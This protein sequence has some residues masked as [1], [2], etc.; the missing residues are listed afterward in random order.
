MK[1]KSYLTRAV[2]AMVASGML[3]ANVGFSA[4]ET[5]SASDITSEYTLN[6]GETLT[7]TGGVLAHN[8]VA[9]AQGKGDIILT[10]PL[11]VNT[12]VSVTAD[13]YG[14]K[15]SG[16][17]AITGKNVNIIVEGQGVY[18][19]EAHII[20]GGY[21]DGVGAV[22]GN[23]VLLD[24]VESIENGFLRISAHR[25][26][27]G[28]NENETAT[29]GVGE[30]TGN[31]VE[32]NVGGTY[33]VHNIHGG[34]SKGYADVNNNEVNL[35][36]GGYYAGY[37]ESKGIHILGAES[38]YGS[39]SGNV[40]NI[41][42]KD[43]NDEG[44]S[45][46]FFGCIDVTGGAADQSG[47]AINNKVVMTAPTGSYNEFN[48]TT[49][50]GYTGENNSVGICGG[51][52]NGFGVAKNNVVDISNTKI[53][54]AT[55]TN[56]D[57]ETSKNFVVGGGS[58]MGTVDSNGVTISGSILNMKD[59][60]FVAGGWI[61]K[62]FDAT[63][64]SPVALGSANN[65][66][67]TMTDVTVNSDGQET[68][69][70]ADVYGGFIGL[71]EYTESDM[72]HRTVLAQYY[73]TGGASN[74]TVEIVTTKSAIFD[75]VAGGVTFQGNANDNKVTL[76]GS[77]IVVEND[78]DGGDRLEDDVDILVN[79]NNNI[80][81]LTNITAND[82]VHGGHGNGTGG[83]ASNNEVHISGGKYTNT[84]GEHT[85]KMKYDAGI[86][87]GEAW[88]EAN[89]NIVEIKDATVAVS[90]VVG[91]CISTLTGTVKDNKVIL[92][93]VIFNFDKDN[94]KGSTGTI[95]A[96]G[97]VDNTDGTFTG[98][99]SGN[100]LE[101]GSKGFTVNTGKA[102][103]IQNFDSMT[104]ADGATVTNN[105]TLT[106]TNNGV[107]DSDVEI[108][109]S[110]KIAGTGKLV[111]N[112]GDFT[113]D[114]VVSNAG[115][116][117]INEGGKFRVKN[118]GDIQTSVV[119]NN[120]MNLYSGTLTQTVDNT[121]GTI[122]IHGVVGITEKVTGGVIEI[123]EDGSTLRLD[124]GVAD[125]LVINE[126]VAY[127]YYGDEKPSYKDTVNK[128]SFDAGFTSVVDQVQANTYKGTITLGAVGLKEEFEGEVGST[129]TYQLFAG[130][131]G[132][133]ADFTNF[134]INGSAEA[135]M[136]TYKYVFSDNG[137]N[138]GKLRVYKDWGYSLHDI[139]NNSDK[140]HKAGTVTSYSLNGDKT[141]TEG[142]G[143]LTRMDSTK[144]RELTINGN[145]YKLIAPTG[146]TVNA[147]DTLTLKD[148][149][150]S[151][152]SG[153]A[154]SGAGTTNISG[155][156]EVGGYVENKLAI[157]ES[158]TLTIATANLGNTVVNKGVLALTGDGTLSKDITGSGT[159]T[160]DGTLNINSNLNIGGN[161]IIGNKV[162]VKNAN[163]LG[164][165]S[166]DDQGI[167]GKNVNVSDSS[168]RYVSVFGA[169]ATGNTINV[170]SNVTVGALE[171]VEY[172]DEIRC[173]V[174]GSPLNRE[175]T[176]EVSGNT[177]NIN[178]E[179][180]TIYGNVHG[181]HSEAL[182]PIKNNKVVISG[183]NI[184]V[185]DVD[186]GS[187]DGHDYGTSSVEVSGNSVEITGATVGK[188]VGGAS[189][190]GV[191]K[192]NSVKMTNATVFADVNR[193]TG[194][195]DTSI[196]TDEA[197]VMGANVRHPFA[198]LNNTVE[199]NNVTSYGAVAAAAAGEGGDEGLKGNSLTINGGS[200]QGIYGGTWKKYLDPVP[201]N[202]TENKITV[203]DATVAGSIIAGRTHGYG[204][205][206]VEKEEDIVVGNYGAENGNI[207]DNT[208]TLN[209]VTFQGDGTKKSVELSGGYTMNLDA[210]ISGNKLEIGAK[211][212]TVAPDRILSVK[213]FDTITPATGVV[214][215]NNGVL[216]IDGVPTD[217]AWNVKVAGSG[218]TNFNVNTDLMS[219]VETPVVVIETAELTSSASNLTNNVTNKGTLN[220]ETGTLAKDLT[221]N[222]TLN[223][224]GQVNANGKTEASKIN[225]TA[226]TSVLN[227]PKA[228]V[229]SDGFNVIAG[230]GDKIVGTAGE[231]G[232]RMGGIE[233]TTSDYVKVKGDL[234]TTGENAKLSFLDATLKL[235]E[236][237]EQMT[238]GGTVTVTDGNTTI[239]GA[240]ATVIR[241]ADG[242]VIAAVGAQSDKTVTVTETKESVTTLIKADTITLDSNGNLNAKDL[243]VQSLYSKNV[244]TLT[245]GAETGDN[246]MLAVKGSDGNI[247]KD[248]SGN[249]VPTSVTVNDGS[250]F[251][252]GDEAGTTHNVVMTINE[253]NVA[254]KVNIY[255]ICLNIGKLIM[256]GGKI[257]FDPNYYG[258]T[259]AELTRGGEVD[260]VTDGTVVAM[261]MSA[262]DVKTALDSAGV[263]TTATANEGYTVADGSGVLAL[264]FAVDLTT[265]PDLQIVVD[266]KDTTTDKAFQMGKDSIFIVA[267][268]AATSEA[269]AVKVH[270]NDISVDSTAKLVI[271][272][273]KYLNDKGE[274]V[275]F[276]V[277]GDG[278][279]VFDGVWTPG[280]VYA[281]DPTYTFEIKDGK[282]VTV[283]NK[284]DRIFG[285]NAIAAP[286]MYNRI[287][288]KA[289]GTD[290]N[291]FLKKVITETAG[292]GSTAATKAVGANALNAATSMGEL[293]AVQHGAVSMAN[294]MG[295]TLSENLGLAARPITDGK[296]DKK[297]WASYVNNKETVEDL[298]L[299]KVNADYTAKYRGASVG[300][301]L[302]SSEKAVGGLAITYSKG[303]VNGHNGG[304]TTN[305]DAKYYGI[306]VYNRINVG[307]DSALLY[308]FD[309]LNT[310]NE[311]S[312]HNFGTNITADA[313]VDVLSAGVRYE[314]G[315]TTGKSVLA[316]FVGLRYLH[317]NNKEYTNSL[318]MHFS[319]DKQN[320]FQPSVGLNWHGEFQ[321]PNSVW[322][323]RPYIETGYV[324]NMGNRDCNQ[325]VSFDGA[326]NT[327]AYDVVDSGSYFAKLG[328]NFEVKNFGFGFGYKYQK[329][330]TAKISKW[331]VDLSWKF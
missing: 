135:V 276:T 274:F 317:L 118:A 330:S 256:N 282:L 273:D 121:N 331:N 238:T 167:F 53:Y 63:V 220:L 224:N 213:N 134:A 196:T 10:A 222:G 288:Q 136:G 217:G 318:N 141:E 329:G 28:Y 264:G 230:M 216:N 95:V 307:N 13:I 89:N 169:T 58:L 270:E 51:A 321:A 291:A 130:V 107:K 191:V 156:V 325:V 72:T 198:G 56:E 47:N 298:A 190:G 292:A 124:N 127:N 267:K 83:T 159:V 109:W 285:E 324:W 205:S 315:I 195:V 120:N 93:G 73:T 248:A 309:Y 33:T 308:D 225:L 157:A 19:N 78:I 102:V 181:G 311:I 113:V 17:T 199:L 194:A 57:D 268:Q 211:G 303:D 229:L 218:T 133:A 41:G 62:T 76:S 162:V 263:A 201:V 98:T 186:G 24:S 60:D 281:A 137:S 114:N 188:A 319:A 180:I 45:A 183:T 304:V 42:Y 255:N 1:K 171:D 94:Y 129:R 142:L 105:G 65:N 131:G 210:V 207:K 30:V 82:G 251:T 165:K 138:D 92:D 223:I 241:K 299:A 280:N 277:L 6:K 200:Y 80:L 209:G 234:F 111:V 289:Q 254:G 40:V 37:D 29:T 313:K 66:K 166:Y 323:Y 85:G 175:G 253:L 322:T 206:P 44:T 112:Y 43:A 22:T 179:N 320:V 87:G 36:C 147:G 11:T 115:G 231:L 314:K 269:P 100:S 236:E 297:I 7:L 247:V 77:N 146:I 91:G 284:V 26:T 286:D 154:I 75:D 249:A 173:S 302:W 219:R 261:G 244:L 192:N 182:A 243:Q 189:S 221:G 184:L 132:N 272:A 187:C 163:I 252:I 84:H 174:F 15:G 152:N 49:D 326:P 237:K 208:V 290:A 16:S 31:K 12:G 155:T 305:N 279:K 250:I 67:V 48:N 242:T 193:E 265:A 153:N 52:A 86:I 119:N 202:I 23:K 258:I 246:T 123:K 327:L 70:Y 55:G 104:F 54:A 81:T 59:S 4:T 74:N 316:P 168:M 21:T 275:N 300:A 260:V 145:S 228:N 214:L 235:D 293:A 177:V 176:A 212:V 160:N 328:M 35:K 71:N 108:I 61:V 117:E 68:P 294:Q 139:I 257:V 158:S 125:K 126:L 5:K 310:K 34:K 164:S 151:V 39:V 14:A 240:E 227:V 149:K 150:Y 262:K 215:T 161:D 197:L 116:I 259:S 3:Y 144:A 27:G 140:D 8:I 38:E 148:V 170:G 50:Y 312:Q 296:Y 295:D 178:G 99:R 96:G 90:G 25:L 271:S 245:V 88:T 103:I 9:G 46:K 232:L 306:S 172:E 32:I 283:W 97:F 266:E 301:D 226:N 101:I 203:N 233:Y 20:G 79:A 122:K 185:G 64:T 18:I 110:A 143:T 69:S 106:F 239:S 204:G 287:L 2:L 128:I 278:T